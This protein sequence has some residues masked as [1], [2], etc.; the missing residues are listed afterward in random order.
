[1]DSAKLIGLDLPEF[2]LWSKEHMGQLTENGENTQRKE[3]SPETR[4]ALRKGR[5]SICTGTPS[6]TCDPPDTRV[7][8]LLAYCSLHPREHSRKTKQ[9]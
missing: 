5:P 8:T 7:D 2:G 4:Q 6:L 1:M 9:E 3:M